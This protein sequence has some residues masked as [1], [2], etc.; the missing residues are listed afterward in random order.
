MFLLKKVEL[1]WIPPSNSNVSILI[2]YAV[3]PII[4]NTTTVSENKRRKC[5]DDCTID[6]V[7]LLYVCISVSLIIYINY[8]NIRYMYVGAEQ[9]DILSTVA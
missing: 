3:C 7:A 4:Y 9:L 8:N 1:Q 6:S 2:F 5:T